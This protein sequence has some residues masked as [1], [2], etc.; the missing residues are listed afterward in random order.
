[1]T[2]TVFGIRV[3]Y[4]IAAA[5][6]MLA[7]VAGCSKEGGEA[8]QKN[9]AGELNWLTD[10]DKALEQAKAENKPIMIDFFA[11]WCGPC[12]MLDKHTYTDSNVVEQSR[13]MVV[14]RIDVDQNQKLARQY[15][16]ESIPTIVLLSAQGKEVRREVGFIAVPK[17]LELMRRGVG[18]P[19]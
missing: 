8:E 19:L 11:T 17:M 5:A 10:H 2:S 1:M 15:G 18:T 3:S 14:L 13:S 7:L 4:G 12:K 6:A 9:P 16:I